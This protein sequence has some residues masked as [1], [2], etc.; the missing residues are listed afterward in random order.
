MSRIAR[1]LGW[2]A[3]AAIIFVTLAPIGLRPVTG[4][5]VS[6]ERFGAYAVLGLLFGFGYRKHP[7][8][9][10]TIIVLA[11]AGLEAIQLL[12]A[13]RHGRMPDFLVKAMGGIIGVLAGLGLAI[14]PAFRGE[15]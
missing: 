12:E 4:E 9:M 8:R 6:L 5:P 3:L 2:M 15:H 11:A 13:T 14:L 7:M 10:V 1:L